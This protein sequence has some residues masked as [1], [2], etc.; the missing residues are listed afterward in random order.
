VKGTVA[1]LAYAPV[2]GLRLEL[3]DEL[4]LTASG[5]RGDRQF[6]LVDENGRLVNNKGLGVLQQA[7]ARYGAE[8]RTLELVLPDGEVVG[9][10]V[11]FDGVVETSFWGSQRPAQRVNGPWSDALSELAGRRL[12]LVTS[13]DGA[14]V[15]RGADA[16]ATLVST[17]SLAALADELAVESVDRRRFRMHL[18]VDG[19]PPH[20]E[21]GW[22]GR[23]VRVGEAVLVPRG[24]VGRCAVTTQNPETGRPDLDTLKALARYRGDVQTTEPLPFGV[25]AAVA[26]PGVVRVGDAVEVV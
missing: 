26:E 6:F 12:Q 5:P 18:Y 9:G 15:D 24:N 11:A 21:D 23:R 19:V 16:A 13:V 2:K 1:T 4:E 3:V 8:T 14:A 22:L 7:R 20:A 25:Y 10:E 17:A